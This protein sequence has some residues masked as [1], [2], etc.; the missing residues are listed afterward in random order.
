MSVPNARNRSA[1]ILL[2]TANAISGV[3]QGIS[4]IAIPWY[5]TTRAEGSLYAVLYAAVTL[6]SLVW[7]PYSGTLVDRYS[8]KHIFLVLNGVCAVILFGVAAIGY[9]RGELPWWWVGSVF[10]MTF[11]NFNIHYPNLYAL[12]QEI[13]PPAQYGR[14]TSILEVSNQTTSVL[15]GAAAA[16]LL[17]GTTGG[18]FRIFGASLDIGYDV[19]AWQIHDIF[20]LDGST[21]VVSLLIISAM[22][23]TPIL[24]KSV[25]T[26]PLLQ[27]LRT[28]W[29]YLVEHG[30]LFVFGVASYVVFAA[31]LMTTFYL[32]APYV[33]DHLGESG[34]I[35]ASAEMYYAIGA[36]AAGLLVRI[37][38]RGV[39]LTPS[40]TGMTL[41]A[42]SVYLTLMLTRSLAVTFAMFFLIGIC[43]AGIRIQRVT[44]LFQHLPNEV[45]GRAGSIFFVSN[46]IIR[47][48]FLLIFALPFFHRDGH[49]VYTF[50]MIGGLLLAAAGVLWWNDRRN[51]VS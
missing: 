16:L 42:A 32:A 1:I 4:L 28:G 44:F 8:R 30:R 19:A 17:E 36:I 24:T 45:Y 29:R 50:G 40:I 26:G 2:L 38:L 13:T 6:V 20:L 7:G 39:R 49:I 34:D 33:E 18:A 25:E 35:F 10:L 5:F 11:M 9:S 51:T 14:I 48:V 27:R 23:Y 46:V 22:R 12:M 15:S 21:Y 3:A 43:N 47:S 31:V 41:L 37:L